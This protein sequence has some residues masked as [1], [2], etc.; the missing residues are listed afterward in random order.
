MLT[1]PK[2]D[3]PNDLADTAAYFRARQLNGVRRLDRYTLGGNFLCVIFICAFAWNLAPPYLLIPWALAIC[4]LDAFRIFRTRRSLRIGAPNSATR[5][6]IQWVAWQTGFTGLL[7]GLI[8]V[9]LY[10]RVDPFGLIIATTVTAG[11]IASGAVANAMI[12]E[13]AIAWVGVLSICGFYAMF[14]NASGQTWLLACLLGLYAVFITVASTFISRLFLASEINERRARVRL[15]D[16][17]ESL[18]VGFI[19]WDR[20]RRLMLSNKSARDIIDDLKALGIPSSNLTVSATSGDEG[21]EGPIE[22]RATNGRWFGI[23]ERATRDGGVVAICSD[24]TDRKLALETVGREAH[25]YQ[26]ILKTASDG[27]HVVDE[28]GRLIE[29]S[30]SFLRELGYPDDAIPALTIADWDVHIPR[31]DA[32]GVMRRRME[33][34]PGIFETQHRRRDGTIYDAEVGVQLVVFEGRKHLYCSVRNITDR[35]KAAEERA[36]L[37]RQLRHAL[38]LESIG[39]LT[40][41]IAHDFNNLLAVLIG[42]L[43]MI[44]EELEDKPKVRD[45]VRLCI[46]VVERGASLTRSLLA[47]SRRQPLV[48]VETDLNAIVADMAEILRRTL[49]VTIDIKVVKAPDLWR[50]EVDPGQ[51]QNAL[52]NLALNARDAMRDGG[53]LTVTT[54]NA[55]AHLAETEFRP[56][57][58]PGDFVMLSVTDNGCGM[59]Q[60]VLERV[61][62]P[63][64]TT[65]DTGKGS[66]LGLSMVYGFVNQSGGDIHIESEIGRGTTVRIYLPRKTTTGHAAKGP[67]PKSISAPGK[68]TVLLVEDNEDLRA[69][70][71]AQ[72]TRLGYTVFAAEDAEGGLSLLRQ[73]PEIA[74]LLTDIVLPN[75]INGIELGERAVALRPKLKVLSMTGY[76]EHAALENLSKAKPGQV[77]HKP[78]R[79]EQLASS[80]RAMLDQG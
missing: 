7:Y 20:D 63:F 2:G 42:R 3:L 49:G 41:G 43:Q 6:D 21:L 55:E 33:L 34:P 17:I 36:V 44:Q 25:R 65:K 76:A 30:A 68:E 47:F 78:F 48:P 1:E 15:V 5:A 22:M 70:T 39:Q 13:A 73:K 61:F 9:Y 64:Y 26:T 66:G 35:K 53:R 56:D 16:A 69:L 31:E 24:I 38:K 72:L 77:L 80:I 19:L 8:L 40:G 10:P 14:S 79:V 71:E 54:G 27:I 32:P 4:G 60:D 74:L 59:P 28:Q 58:K 45:W 52:L 62:E 12:P 51:L 37:E 50:C 75:G 67:K 18:S 23:R 11:L 29:A 46:D 57:A